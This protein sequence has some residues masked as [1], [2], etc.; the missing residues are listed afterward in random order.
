MGCNS[1]SLVGDV[2][3]DADADSSTAVPASEI[4]PEGE[5]DAVRVLV[6]SGLRSVEQCRRGEDDVPLECCGSVDS[7]CLVARIGCKVV[8]RFDCG[9][10]DD[11]DVVPGVLFDL[12]EVD[13][14]N[15]AAVNLAE[16][17]EPGPGSGE[18]VESLSAEAL[19]RLAD[20]ASESDE[21]ACTAQASQGSVV[22]TT[23]TSQPAPS[24]TASGTLLKT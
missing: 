13:A 1:A 2:A 5:P 12:A 22:C 23:S 11:R 9:V 14:V 10:L 6:R 20:F 7:R 8:D 15:L 16:E 21:S 4:E 24:N 3:A 18:M 19:E 17:Y